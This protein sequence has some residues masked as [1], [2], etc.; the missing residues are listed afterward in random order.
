M[1]DQHT[2]CGCTHTVAYAPSLIVRIFRD[3]PWPRDCL[4]NHGSSWF[5]EHR[6]HSI[7]AQRALIMRRTS[8]SPLL[9]EILSALIVIVAI[10][11]V[12][13]IEIVFG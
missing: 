12:L 7:D 13:S 6:Q 5:H 8:G 10:G 11:V 1:C 2:N 4:W 9:R 3:R